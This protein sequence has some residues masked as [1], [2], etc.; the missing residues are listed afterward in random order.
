MNA[1]SFTENSYEQAIIAL[2]KDMG[3]TY[4]SGYDIERDNRNP[5]YEAVLEK[6]L[7]RINPELTSYGIG[8]MM[9]ALKEIDR[10]DLV[11]RNETFTDYLQ[12]G[13]PVE[14]KV[15][16]EFRTINARLVDYDHPEKNDFRYASD[17]IAF[18]RREGDFN[19]SAACYPEVHPES[20]NQKEDILTLN[21][22]L[23]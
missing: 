6:S 14:D 17:L 18:I 13:L 8:E 1:T 7:R 21:F 11:S 9:K 12:N 3:Y 2:F 16:G 10:A 23:H 4:E 15:G 5:L 20:K 19:I 22:F